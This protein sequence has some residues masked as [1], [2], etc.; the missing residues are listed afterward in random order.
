M[1]YVSEQPKSQVQSQILI[2][3]YPILYMQYAHIGHLD[4]KKFKRKIVNIFFPSV[5]TYVFGAQ[6]NHLIETVLLSTNNICFGREIRKLIIN[7]AHT[8]N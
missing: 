4:K 6:K 1:L 7:C 2:L 3:T 5:L 8:L